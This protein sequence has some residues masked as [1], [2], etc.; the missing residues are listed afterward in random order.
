[1]ERSRQQQR[2]DGEHQA[3][4]T[5]RVLVIGVGGLGC[6]AA[7]HL[8]AAG[9]G[10]L[11]LVDPDT[12]ETSNLN[13]Q[14]L[15]RTS[16]LGS[17]KVESARA[18][19]AG[20]A[21][22]RVEAHAERIT[23]ANAERFFLDADFVIDAT[24]GIEPKYLINDAAVATGRPYSH[25]GILGFVG[26][27]MTVLPRR[28]ACLRCL[29]PE[30]PEAGSLPTCQ[31][32]GILGAVGGLIG[33]MQAG[34]ALKYL[35]GGGDLLTDRLLTWDGRVWRGRTVSVSRNPRCPACSAAATA[36]PHEPHLSRSRP[37]MRSHP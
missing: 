22:T 18:R 33:T 28:S 35:L 8:A 11:I 10:T 27:T 26:Q 21:S 31:E 1:M 9:V 14:I 5:A 24:D 23:A 4:R 13:R 16:A 3:L 34:E 20:F 19:L 36:L 15:H 29:F 12:V 7:L 37:A 30:P 25:A 2:T 17:A 6:P 32:A